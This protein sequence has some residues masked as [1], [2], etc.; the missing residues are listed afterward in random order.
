MNL[1]TWIIT[2]YCVNVD[3][4]LWPVGLQADLLVLTLNLVSGHIL[5][6]R[7]LE[8]FLEDFSLEGFIK[9]IHIQQWNE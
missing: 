2:N 1:K 6:S 8:V 5:L 3:N 7:V 4:V 9:C